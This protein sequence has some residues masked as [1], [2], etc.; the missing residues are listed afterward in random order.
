[1]IVNTM[2]T[3]QYTLIVDGPDLQEPANL[4][5]CVNRVGEIQSSD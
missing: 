3:H 2:T 5:R 4:G 1:M